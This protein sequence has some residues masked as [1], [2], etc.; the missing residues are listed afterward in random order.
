MD[1]EARKHLRER[2]TA[3]LAKKPWR[4]RY[5]E[6]TPYKSPCVE[7]CVDHHGQRNFHCRWGLRTGDLF[8]TDL[9]L[10][11]TF[12]SVNSAAGGGDDQTAGILGAITR[13]F[14]VV[15]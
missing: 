4:Q 7:L 3:G 13:Q 1:G 9:H 8:S 5:Y 10:F 2:G 6:C 15:L 14:L 12:V 11:G